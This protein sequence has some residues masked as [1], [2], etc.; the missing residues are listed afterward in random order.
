[1]LKVKEIFCKKRFLIP[2]IFVLFLFLTLP[3]D[4]ISDNEK[5]ENKKEKGLKEAESPNFFVKSDDSESKSSGKVLLYV[6]I[7]AL[8]AGGVAYFILLKGKKEKKGSIDVRSTPEGARIYLDGSDTGKVTNSKL[9][10]INP[11]THTVTLKLQGYNDYTTTVNISAG[12]T[13]SVSY[14]FLT[15]FEHVKSWQFYYPLDIAVDSSG[16]VYV[17]F[18]VS[19]SYHGKKSAI[20]KFTS[21]GVEITRLAF[22]WGKNCGQFARIDGIAFDKSGFIYLSDSQTTADVPK[23]TTFVNHRIQKLTS[24]MSPVLCWGGFG[25]STGQFS[26]PAS[27][28]VDNSYSVYVVDS[29]NYRIQKF[30]QNGSFITMWG[31]NGSGASQFGYIGGIAVDNSGYVYVAD[32]SNNRIQKFTSNGSFVKMWGSQGSGDG[33]FGGPNDVVLDN[34]GY[35]YVL[36]EGNSRIQKFTSNGDFIGKMGEPYGIRFSKPTGIAIDPTGYYL[37][38]ADYGNNEI[39]KFRIK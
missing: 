33:Q 32:I 37:Y 16:F 8:V 3:S 34:L 2:F 19:Y 25:N 4:S 30:N 1:M 20:A 18:R 14:N 6:V 36:D 21:D 9:E 35:V 12:Q 22:E 5:R 38:V 15:V 11:G 31:S 39:D 24:G 7:G 27:I 17:L 28:A 23:P 29:G 26:Y 13:A 10:N